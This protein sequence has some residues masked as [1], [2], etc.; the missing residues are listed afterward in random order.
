MLEVLWTLY[1]VLGLTFPED[2][3]LLTEHPEARGY[4]LLSFLL[5]Y[6]DVIQ[7]YMAGQDDD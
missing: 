2:V 6:D 5:D 1:G 7:D 4:F 3:K